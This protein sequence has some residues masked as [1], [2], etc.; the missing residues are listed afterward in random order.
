MLRKTLGN[1]TRVLSRAAVNPLQ[2][3]ARGL[4]VPAINRQTKNMFAEMKGMFDFSAPAKIPPMTEPM[5]G[6]NL[7]AE[8]VYPKTPPATE[9][10]TLA[11][12]VRVASE[13]T[14]GS[15][16]TVGVYIDAGSVNEDASNQGVSHLLERMAFKTT[17][18]R[19][20]LRF[21]R[22]VEAI[23]A[24][25]MATAT[26]EQMSYTAD[27]IKTHL[28][29]VVELLADTVINPKLQEHE[30]TEE[31]GKMGGQLQAIMKNPGALV[32]EVLHTA[33]FRGGLAN[34][35]VWSGAPLSQQA[36]RDFVAT[37]ITG[38]R[39]VIAASGCDH[40]DLLAIAEP[41]FST[42]P[43][44]AA[45]EVPTTYG[46]GDMREF[47]MG[48]DV[49]VALGFEMKGG[50]KNLKN[51]TTI[52]VLSTLMG[53]GGSFSAGG[54]GKGMYSRLYTRV[55]NRCEYMKSCSTFQ[56]GYNDTG[57]FGI[58]ARAD[59]SKGE[60]MVAVVIAELQAVAAKGSISD[61]ELKRAKNATI[62][63]V[64]MNLESKAIVT[65]D[66]GRQIL[67]YGVRKAPSEFIADVQKVTAADLQACA[68]ELLKSPLSMASI[69]DISKVPA[70]DLV[71]NRLK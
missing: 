56:S 10:T 23:G 59:G 55:L 14:P 36:A 2:Q 50:W 5:T 47:S 9:I 51:A 42:L 63:S 40:K 71:S 53:G 65:E 48:S 7:L 60:E 33:A 69:G 11:N 52:S 29:A 26:R 38:P 16:V 58:V 25:L 41:L 21:T 20:H 68:A 17:L 28:P 1:G 57:I 22:E 54:P 70:Y 62:S 67:T 32:L 3:T 6:V 43:K 45:P 35:F 19:S 39:V 49:H 24:N 15:S 27:C 61:I 44:V 30:M 18:N 13:N 4:A 64:L 34:Q 46:G 31:M 66:I 12:G 8:P 37:N